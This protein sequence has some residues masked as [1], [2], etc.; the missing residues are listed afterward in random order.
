M[1]QEFLPALRHLVSKELRA[2]GFSQNRISSM[3]GVTQASV[4]LYLSS[5][6]DRSYSVLSGLSLSVEEADRYAA[7]LAEDAK[8]NA[9]DAVGTLGMVW[10]ELL[11]RGGVCARHR[12]LYPVLADC[13]VCIRKYG[14]DR[15]AFSEAVSEVAEAVRRLEASQDFASV[16]PEVSVNLAL[17]V[18]KAESAAEVV[19]VPGR[20][21]RVKGRP[22]AILPPEPG[23]SRHL[24]KVLILVRT[25]RPEL[26]ACVNLRYDRKMA[27]VL[28]KL[29]LRA[30]KI[31]G[32]PPSASGDPTVQALERRLS[33]VDEGFDVL[34]DVGGNGVEPNVYLF[35]AS[36]ARVA[37][38]ALRVSQ[39][40]SA[41]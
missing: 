29:R 10:T 25:I 2:Q 34:V 35:A 28:K 14:K 8:R 30:L 32:Y 40:Y 38:I 11:G 33:S 9:V 36:A 31:G 37:D 27:A 5:G 13:D 3:L 20:I 22:K 23:A 39:A 15:S 6:N 18:G 12:S 26:R 41:R 19:A 7:L 16:M 1:A 17:A 21:V 24:S 4:S